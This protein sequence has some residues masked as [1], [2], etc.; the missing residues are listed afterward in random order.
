MDPEE[1]S[2]QRRARLCREVR[3]AAP[4]CGSAA[5]SSLRL[6]RFFYPKLYI[7]AQLSQRYF[8]LV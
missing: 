1:N 8:R 6:I 2:P 3:L 7:R 5:L 4:G